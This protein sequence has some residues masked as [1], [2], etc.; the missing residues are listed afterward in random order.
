M[1][2]FAKEKESGYTIIVGCGR[3]GSSLANAMSDRGDSVL[4]IDSDREAFEKLSPSFGGIIMT[5]DATEIFVLNEAQMGAATAVISVTNNDNTNI[6]VAQMA[7]EMF[8]IQ[9]VIARLYDPD[10]EC[11]YREF[12]I[13]TICPAVLSANEIGRLLRAS[14][15][16]EGGAS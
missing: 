7:K 6:L 12:G 2:L 4:I 15:L 11:V 3:L 16:D 14:K 13:D 8:H 10:R 9:H 5:G 1:G